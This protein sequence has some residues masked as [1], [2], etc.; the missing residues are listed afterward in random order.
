[1]YEADASTVS[2]LL[3]APKIGNLPRLQDPTRFYAL[4][5]S[6][7]QGRAVVRDWFATSVGDMA[8]RLKG[9]FE[10]L[11]LFSS[12]N[13]PRPSLT[14]LLRSVVSGGDDKNI[15]PNLAADFMQAILRGQPLPHTLLHA[16]IHRC[17]AEGPLSSR[18][19][20]GKQSPGDRSHLRMQIIKALLRRLKDRPE[21]SEVKP[22]LDEA[23][24][25]TAYLLGRLFSV[26]EQMQSTLGSR[27]ATITD[28]Y[29]GSA[30]TAPAIA[31][32]RLVEL[33]RHHLSKLRKEKPGAAVNLDKTLTVVIGSLPAKNLPSVLTVEEQGLFAI[34]YYHQ[35]Q[36]FFAK[37]E[38]GQ[39]VSQEA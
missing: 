6:G 37:K 20:S 28:R 11:D 12:R 18:C 22:M 27:N 15:L 35:R 5:I 38:D 8:T 36:A 17:K 25:Q 16:A 31:F 34:G 21:L 19:Y 10:D 3:Q 23:N 30:S 9:Y 26:L 24:T 39:A 7:G 32:S 13:S 2:R 4:T 1:M 29:Y 33:S 14:Y